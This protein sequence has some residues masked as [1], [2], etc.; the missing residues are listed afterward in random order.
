MQ[1]I[2]KNSIVK[3]AFHVNASNYGILLAKS[4]LDR[5]F[6]LHHHDFYEFEIVV[7]G[8]IT[9]TVDGRE[10]RL[11]RGDFH[12]LA[13]EMPHGLMA[14]RR[15]GMIYNISV[16]LPDAPP[17]VREAVSSFVFPCYGR[18][19]AEELSVVE[20]LY[21][22][23]FR[24]AR[25]HAPHERERVS[26]LVVYILTV[27]AEHAVL[28][29]EGVTAARIQPHVQ[30][31]MTFIRERYAAELT[32]TDVAAA[33]GLS[34][35]YLSMLF[36]K[37]L[38]VGFKEYLNAIRVRHA[39]QLLASTDRSVTEIA[40]A[41]GFGSFSTFERRFSRIAE[42]TPREYRRRFGAQ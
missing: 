20:G 9:H 13:P 7:S 37:E 24:D 19:P 6:P 16:F 28:F 29:G 17:A 38:G 14:E 26:S 10:E 39:M 36:A 33:L 1:R 15:E 11:A 2:K 4:T 5:D 42:M 34:E 27:L 35:G 21:D 12:C 23:L 8:E 40:L 22:I 41:S 30:A 25:S 18:L 31:A 32:L 3:Y